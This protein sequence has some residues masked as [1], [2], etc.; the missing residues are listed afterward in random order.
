MAYPN[1]FSFETQ[2]VV[3]GLTTS[4]MQL[5][6]LDSYGRL[7]KERSLDG[8][9]NSFQETLD[10]FSPGLYF[11]TLLDYGIPVSTLKLLK[12]SPGN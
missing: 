4:H 10:E 2:L 5:V 7:V 6:I 1:P 8:G 11:V 9:E 3:K 12:V